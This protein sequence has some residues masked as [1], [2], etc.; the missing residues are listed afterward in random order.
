[1]RHFIFII[2]LFCQILSKA[3]FAPQV[4]QMGTTAIYKDSNIIKAWAVGCEVKLGWQNMADTSLCKAAV[5]EIS[6]IS[7]A[8]GN[9]VFSLGDGGE[10]LLSFEHPII[11][12]PG[13]DF[14]VFENGFLVDSLAFLELAFVEVSSDGQNFFRFPAISNTDSLLQ[15]SFFSGMN[16]SKINNL[17]GKYIGLYGTPFDL[18]ELKNMAGLDVN[19]ITKVKIID[20]IGSIDMAYSRKDSRNCVINDPWPTAFPS[21]GFD[22]DAVAVLNQDIL[23]NV[24]EL[25]PQNEL[26]IYPNPVAENEPIHIVSTQSIE[27]ISL[28]DLNGVQIWVVSENSG[29]TNFTA[30]MNFS[31]GI[32]FLRVQTVH[33]SSIYKLF[34][35]NP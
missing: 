28:S 29:F 27:S 17:A 10:A 25:I 18:E 13:P 9:G 19:N 12:G 24:S 33:S 26:S 3:Q 14:A 7:G 20:V 4:G 6:N 35:Q 8:A 11:N 1:M 32:Y 22:L 34:I 21:S 30:P 23:K 15:L 31:S 16:A 5:G 2:F